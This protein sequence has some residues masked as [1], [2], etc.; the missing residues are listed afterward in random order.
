MNGWSFNIGFDKVNEDKIKLRRS[1][2]TPCVNELTTSNSEAIMK[3]VDR[4]IYIITSHF[5]ASN[6]NEIPQSILSD[7]QI[8]CGHAK[9][10][11]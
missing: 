3:F 1:F 10:R 8:S 2:R 4:L 6:S 5:N 11:T 7:A 9:P